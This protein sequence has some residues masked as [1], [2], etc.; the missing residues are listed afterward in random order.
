[1]DQS[2]TA[3][4][5]NAA[6]WSGIGSAVTHIWHQ[7]AVPASTA[8]VL[9][10]FLYLANALALHITTSSLFAI[11]PFNSSRTLTVPTQSLPAFNSLYDAENPDAMCVG[12]QL[13]ATSQLIKSLIVAKRNLTQRSHYIFFQLLLRME[14]RVSAPSVYMKAH[15]MMCWTSAR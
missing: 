2:L 9:S 10:T 12:F 1:M 14:Q 6:A 7:N 11:V 15:C 3:T 13:Q 5:D 8:V 4:H